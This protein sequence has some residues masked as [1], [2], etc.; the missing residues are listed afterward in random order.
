MCA[1]EKLLFGTAGV[2]KS[3]SGTSTLSGIQRIAELGLDCLE[4]EFVQGVKMGSDTAIKLNKEAK[5]LSIS[6]SVHAPYFINLNSAEAGKRLASQERILSSAR[7]AELLGAQ[8]VVVHLGY[9]GKNSA[10]D[11]SEKIKAGL[12]EVVSILR[13]ERSPVILRPETMGKKTQFGSLEEILLLCREVEG[14]MPCVD[15]SHIHSRSGKMNTYP[16]FHRILKKIA[17][18][19]GNAALQNM[20]IHIAGSMYNLKG[21]MKHLNLE[22]SDFRFDEWIQTLKDFDVKGMVICESPVQETDAMM[23]KN[24][25]YE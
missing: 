12:E 15:F 5:K 22:E 18:K 4:V 21:E 7:L 3:S 8:S 13:K 16:E 20:H 2:P 25:F 17:K 6:L 19:L 24:L 11:A 10:E 9:Y 23:L 1:A 14:L